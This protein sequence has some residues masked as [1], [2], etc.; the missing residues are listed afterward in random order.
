MWNIDFEHAY[1]IRAGATEEQIAR[2]VMEWNA[3]LSVQEMDEIKG[4]QVNP[5][6]KSSPF[7]DQ[8][9]PLNPTG[10]KLPRRNFPASYL[11]LLK[12]SNGGEFQQGA[13]LFQFFNTD[14][15]REMNLAYELPEYM[16]GAVSFA[17][18][19][20]GNHYMFDMRE[21]PTNGEY[22]ILFAHSGNLGYEDCERV[23]DSLPALCTETWELY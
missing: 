19:G 8:Y 1:D 10:W 2:F 14:D 16:P 4:R 22:A 23:A 13:R 17:M 21:A 15:L 3:G 12:Y 11:D 9:V 18:D 7:Y 6:H 5:F 20:S